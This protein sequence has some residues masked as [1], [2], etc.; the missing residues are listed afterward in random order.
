MYETEAVQSQQSGHT[1]AYIDGLWYLF[2][3]DFP[4]A[5][6]STCIVSIL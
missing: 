4:L 5:H 2:K 6:F 3:C 1:N